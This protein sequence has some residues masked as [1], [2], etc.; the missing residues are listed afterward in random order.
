M[1]LKIIKNWNHVVKPCDRIYFLG[2][3][4]LISTLRKH[5]LNGHIIFIKGNH[6]KTTWAKQH[7]VSYRGHV[8]LL[9]HNPNP[10]FRRDLITNNIFHNAA[11]RT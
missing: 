6:D 3:F 10:T 5:K 8:F 7:L 11:P 1:N 9:I 4:G 2:D